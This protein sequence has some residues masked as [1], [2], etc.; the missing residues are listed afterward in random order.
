MAWGDSLLSA[1]HGATNVARSAVSEIATGARG[2]GN[3]VA[4]TVQVLAGEAQA[5]AKTAKAD[6]VSGAKAVGHAAVVVAE[7]GAEAAKWAAD[8]TKK[9]AIWA[10]QK[11]VAAA[12]STVAGIAAVYKATK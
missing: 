12:H 7:K 9:A 11:G 3:A 1:W 10:E 6:A 8:T 4:H 5:I 2:V